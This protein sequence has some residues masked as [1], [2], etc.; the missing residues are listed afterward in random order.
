MAF[1]SINTE[2]LPPKY[3]LYM[4]AF[5]P[6]FRIDFNCD[7]QVHYCKHNYLQTEGEDEIIFCGDQQPVASRADKQ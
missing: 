6:V 5:K 3:K 1:L 4:S 2:L 7:F